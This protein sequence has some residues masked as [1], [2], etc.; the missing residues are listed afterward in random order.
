MEGATGGMAHP[1]IGMRPLRGHDQQ[2]T[3]VPVVELVRA[4]HRSL[5]DRD[6]YPLPAGMLSRISR[7]ARELLYSERV[8]LDGW[9][10][11]QN[12]GGRPALSASVRLGPREAEWFVELLER[13]C[14]EMG[15]QRQAR[16]QRLL[17]GLT[18]SADLLEAD[19]RR[20][21]GSAPAD[22]SESEM[23]DALRE[24]LGR[25]RDRV[26]HR[27]D[28]PDEEG[29]LA[30]LT[31]R[32]RL[33]VRADLLLSADGGEAR[34]DEWRREA[35]AEPSV[36]E[37]WQFCGYDTVPP[38]PAVGTLSRAGDTEFQPL[39]EFVGRRAGQ[40]LMLLADPSGPRADRPL[41]ADVRSVLSTPGERQR[42]TE[43]IR[44]EVR[45]AAFPGGLADPRLRALWFQ[46]VLFAEAQWGAAR[47]A[48][49]V[50]SVQHAADA[51]TA[52]LGIRRIVPGP[53]AFDSLRCAA[54]LQSSS[55]WPSGDGLA[56]DGW[57]EAVAE[58]GFDGAR[59][60][61][62]AVPHPVAHESIGLTPCGAR[63]IG[64]FGTDA[65]NR[66]SRFGDEGVEWLVQVAQAGYRRRI[67][68]R[69]LKE[70]QGEVQVLGDR[71]IR[72]WHG[73][74]LYQMLCEARTAV[75]RYEL[76]RPTRQDASRMEVRSVAPPAADPQAIA[77]ARDEDPLQA[78]L[79]EPR[80]M[81]TL[82]GVGVDVVEIVDLGPGT[83]PALG[84][85]AAVWRRQAG[86]D[87]DKGMRY[88]L[89][90]LGEF[91][92]WLEAGLKRDEAGFGREVA[93][94]VF[95]GRVTPLR[96]ALHRYARCRT[97]PD[98]DTRGSDP[99]DAVRRAG[100]RL[101]KQMYDAVTRMVM[102]IERALKAEV[103]DD[104]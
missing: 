12:D 89:R 25:L 18:A 29:V 48:S 20:E 73:T 50:R 28:N 64:M 43:L 86:D 66:A 67:R 22:F 55:T 80:R 96:Q 90:D 39:P 53:A 85:L 49:A 69:L 16:A 78:L 92:D 81:R 34:V 3:Q 2:T 33:C 71:S 19:L 31:E 35:A 59:S 32:L 72:Q 99:P 44:S 8:V 74:T 97:D 57:S 76:R 40:N 54:G 17:A 21:A 61:R 65:G 87:I 62:F 10:P 24:W 9:Q 60:S 77:R 104:G 42:V 102:E 38:G 94:R 70:D 95:R 23:T 26:R 6:L 68:Q 7:A 88:R 98:A 41:P 47:V 30:D 93:Q 13:L 15:P 84:R 52:M 82:R 45:R 51:V 4:W 46:A 27:A 5:I 36:L 11:P 63:L 100:Q 58:V 103:A 14:L 91:L 83:A 56:A 79:F 75:T 37:S 1:G 101:S